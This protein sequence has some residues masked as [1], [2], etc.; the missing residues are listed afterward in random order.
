MFAYAQSNVLRVASV[1]YPAGKT[2]ALPVEL[3]N[4]SDITG[5]QFDISV[6]YALATDTA[7]KLALK[8]GGIANENAMLTG[9]I[10]F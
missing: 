9:K 1:S 3:D 10:V 7:G 2:L 8:V 6:P 5:V 4:S